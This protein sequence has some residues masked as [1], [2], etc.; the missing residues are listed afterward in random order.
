MNDITELVIESNFKSEL[1]RKFQT[2][3]CFK[4]TL[5]PKMK[6]QI[7]IQFRNEI[8]NLI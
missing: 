4:M 1:K 6:F 5:Q 8:L 3:A 2:E 7:K